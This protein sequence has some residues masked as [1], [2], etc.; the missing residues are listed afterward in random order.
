MNKECKKSR[1]PHAEFDAFETLGVL[2]GEEIAASD[3]PFSVNVDTYA[4][5]TMKILVHE[6]DDSKERA[7]KYMRASENLERRVHKKTVPELNFPQD[8]VRRLT[9]LENENKLLQDENARLGENLGALQ[10]ENA[11][12]QDEISGQ[13]HKIQGAGKRVRDAKDM[14]GKEEAKAKDAVHNKQQRVLSERKMKTERNEARAE[15][16]KYKKR[17]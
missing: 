11:A 14:A 13:K 16:E 4:E 9:R 15:F 3:L 17:E 2:D 1:L 5:D 10:C 7:E 12:L 8:V 6:R